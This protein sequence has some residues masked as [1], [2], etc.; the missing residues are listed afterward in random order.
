SR[1]R[2]HARRRE[3]RRARAGR[4]RGV[5]S[6]RP[7]LLL[8]LGRCS[9]AYP[10]PEIPN[11]EPRSVRPEGL[12]R[13][14]FGYFSTTLT[15]VRSTWLSRFRLKVPLIDCRSS[16]GYVYHYIGMNGPG[17]QGRTSF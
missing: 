7:W 14:L 3:C 10:P 8:S 16:V 17:P 13:Q 9:R 4:G 6:S 1:G 2:A 11:L 15:C 5:W 12:T